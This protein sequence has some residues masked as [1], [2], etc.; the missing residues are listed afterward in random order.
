MKRK[1]VLKKLKN[2]KGVF[3]NCLR[4]VVVAVVSIS[5]VVVILRNIEKHI[6]SII[7][8]F[9]ISNLNYL[10]LYTLEDLNI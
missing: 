5:V 1:V 8:T 3:I 7:V 2:K 4:V 10:D 9:R 6:S